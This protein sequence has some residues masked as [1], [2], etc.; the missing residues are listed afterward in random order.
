[1]VNAGAYDIDALTPNIA[2]G[3]TTRDFYYNETGVLTEN[4]PLM[5]GRGSAAGG[6]YA[7]VGDMLNFHKALF[8]Y[9]LLSPT[10]TNLLITGKVQARENAQYA[11]GF[12]DKI[13][14]S[15]R[16]VGNDGR[17]LG[18]CTTYAAYTE[19]G[20][21]LIILSNS[22]NDCQLVQDFLEGAQLK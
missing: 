16:M 3:Y 11:Y 13:V 14:A 18:V 19:T 22:D 7:T 1:M 6:H 9:Q 12:F 2:I 21:V 15:R 20:Y 5:P 10:M 4:T 17:D 8:D